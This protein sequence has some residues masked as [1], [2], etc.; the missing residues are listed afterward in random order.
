MRHLAVLNGIKKRH[1]L[2][3]FIKRALRS[4]ETKVNKNSGDLEVPPKLNII[5]VDGMIDVELKQI[6]ITVFLCFVSY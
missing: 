2:D 4:R 3:S 5:P 1:Q 6:K